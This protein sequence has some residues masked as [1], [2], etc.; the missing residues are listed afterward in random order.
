MLFIALIHCDTHLDLAIL[1][2]LAQVGQDLDR[3]IKERFLLSR[4][5][6]LDL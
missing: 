4:I 6:Y 3:R 2:L 1:Q 5:E